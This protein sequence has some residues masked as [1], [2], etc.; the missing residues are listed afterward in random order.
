MILCT[1]RSFTRTKNYRTLILHKIRY[2]VVSDV[3]VV[4]LVL[5]QV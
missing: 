4:V 3:V 1:R 5:V 2:F